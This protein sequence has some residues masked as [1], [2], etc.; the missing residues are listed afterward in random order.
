MRMQVIAHRGIV[1]GFPENTLAGL[2]ACMECGLTWAEVDI[3]TTRDGHTVLLHDREVART[4]SGE[5][6][7]D[8]MS[9]A[10]LQSLAMVRDS[11][12]PGEPWQIPT[13]AEALSL[14]RGRLRLYLDCRDVDPV[15]LTAQLASAGAS[16]EVLLS[17]PPALFE[18]VRAPDMH[19]VPLVAPWRGSPHDLPAIARR[20]EC[21]V[22]EVPAVLANE[23]LLEQARGLGLQVGCLTLGPEDEPATWFRCR[24]LGVAWIMTNHPLEA[25]QTLQ[26]QVELG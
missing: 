12:V 23:K 14:V 9:L 10:E 20:S 16:D 1:R 4:T 25:A 7:C 5:G 8:Q 19:G 13:L 17:L 6:C 15:R 24:D 18:Q 22:A 2:A 26:S 3:R 21:R 11:A